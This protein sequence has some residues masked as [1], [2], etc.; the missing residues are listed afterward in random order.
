MRRRRRRRRAA[1]GAAAVV[2]AWWR[3]RAAR[4]P[5]R[6]PGRQRRLRPPG[7]CSSLARMGELG[8]QY[9]AVDQLHKIQS[10]I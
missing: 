5:A 9:I 3:R 7:S 8:S 2:A 1:A 6:S 4:R 10:T